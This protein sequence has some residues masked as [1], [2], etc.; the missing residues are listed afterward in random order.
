VF[1]ELPVIGKYFVALNVLAPSFLVAMLV[2]YLV[3]KKYPP[4][5]A[6]I[7][8]IEAIDASPETE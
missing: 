8:M 1:Q 4:R 2:G 5:A 3:S 6:A 7:E